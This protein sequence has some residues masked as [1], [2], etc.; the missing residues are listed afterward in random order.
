LSQK[1][2]VP[3]SLLPKREGQL[4]PRDRDA[5][6]NVIGVTRLCLSEYIIA[7]FKPAGLSQMH[8]ICR[9]HM[10]L[11]TLTSY[12]KRNQRQGFLKGGSK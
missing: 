12:E 3:G 5:E 6:L 1:V 10:A 11:S 9:L 4:I 8:E 2:F 7:I